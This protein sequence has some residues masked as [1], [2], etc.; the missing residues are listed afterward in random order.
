MQTTLTVLDYSIDDCPEQ[1][2]HLC[3]D[4]GLIVEATVYATAERDDYGVPGSPTFY[5]ISVT[6]ID[7]EINGVAVKHVSDDLYELAG[8]MAVEKGDWDYE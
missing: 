6:D 8:E 3:D 4:D 1:F 5:S 2:K 7:F